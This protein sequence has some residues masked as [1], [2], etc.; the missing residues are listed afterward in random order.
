MKITTC[1]HRCRKSKIS[2]KGPAHVIAELTG[3]Q[4]GNSLAKKQASCHVSIVLRAAQFLL[5]TLL[6]GVLLL[7][8]PVSAQSVGKSETNAG[9]IRGTVLD[10]NDDVVPNATVVLQGPVA[11]DRR[12]IVTKD[13][14]VFAFHHVTAE[15]AYQI[16]VSAQGFG[17]WSSSVTLEP[18][19]DKTVTGIKLRLEALEQRVAVGYSS[20]ESKEVATRQLKAEEQQRL[21]GFIPNFFVTYERH[22]E[23]L[24]SKMKFELALKD[25]IQPFFLARA[26]LLAGIG[27]AQNSPDY[28]QGPEGYGKRFGTSA[29]GVVSESMIGNAMLPVLLHQDPRYFYR[30]TGTKKSRLLHALSSPFVCPGDNG[31]LQPNYSTWGG[32]LGSAAIATAYYPS[33]DRTAGR[34][35]G[36]F[37]IGMALHEAISLAQEFVFAKHTSKKLIQQQ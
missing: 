34:V 11:S 1:S 36:N 16:T 22:P 4:P 23:P 24:T 2:E 5:L 35:F 6:A 20:K 9:N 28:G 15:I 17:D 3:K 25:L 29:A 26:G 8:I 31:N 19:Q 37:A 30:G 18:G 21:L 10:P 12:T 7:A 33:S 27:Q 13:D 14:G 32:A